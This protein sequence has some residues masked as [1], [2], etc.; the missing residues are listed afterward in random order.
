[1]GWT[2]GNEWC[3][4]IWIKAGSLNELEIYYKYNGVLKIIIF[5]NKGELP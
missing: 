3:Q 4:G 2:A 1:M 5:V